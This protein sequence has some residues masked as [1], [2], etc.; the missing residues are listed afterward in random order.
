MILRTEAWKTWKLSTPIILGELTQMAL[1]II[2]NMMVGSISYQHLAAAALVAWAISG[3]HTGEMPPELRKL[4][5]ASGLGYLS[6][7]ALDGMTPKCI[8]LL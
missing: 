4:L 1:G 2:D 5:V 3:K 6:H 8:P 7:L